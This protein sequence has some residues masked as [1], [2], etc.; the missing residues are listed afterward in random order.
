MKIQYWPWA[1]L[2]T[3]CYLIEIATSKKRNSQILEMRSQQKLSAVF[4]HLPAIPLVSRSITPFI[5]YDTQQYQVN[6]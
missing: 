5:S 2:T 1:A 4:L 6:T 3:K